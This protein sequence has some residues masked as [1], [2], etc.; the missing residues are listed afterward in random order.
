MAFAG[1][2]TK[3]TGAGFRRLQV[4]E[5]DN[6]DLPL[7]A[8]S[9][10]TAESGKHASGA[11]ALTLTIPDPQILH[12]TGDDRV[13]SI[14][15]LPATEGIGIELRT[16]KTNLELDAMLSNVEAFQLG[17]MKAMLM[18]TD[19]QG[20]EA[21]VCILG[22]RQSQDTDPTSATKGAR[23]WNWVLIPKALVYPKAGPM[24]EGGQDEN[25]Y[26]VVPQVVTRWPW[27]IAFTDGTEGAEEA[28]IIR[29]ICEGAPVMDA[30]LGDAA[31][32]EFTL[33][34]TAMEKYCDVELDEIPKVK[35]WTFS[36]DDDVVT[37]VTDSISITTTTLTFGAAP[38]ADDVIIAFYEQ[39][40]C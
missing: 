35:V 27:G 38:E 15:M 14:D 13:D 1:T 17:D 7:V 2:T 24:E 11:K 9:S 29:G 39:A 30:W 16:G 21:Q 37:D 4:F 6:D 20:C 31:R 8:E 22:Y 28:Q 36:K 32:V 34:K 5:L 3:A 19:Q 25:T 26:T 12:N 33:S 18:Q 40:G 10:G 23:R